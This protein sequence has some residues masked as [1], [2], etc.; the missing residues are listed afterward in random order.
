MK[1]RNVLHIPKILNTS[2]TLELEI[3]ERRGIGKKLVNNN[4]NGI[5]VKE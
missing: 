4:N 2:D 1:E 3:E 5:L